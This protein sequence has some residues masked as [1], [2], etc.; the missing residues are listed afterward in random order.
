MSELGKVAK[1]EYVGYNRITMVGKIYEEIVFGKTRGGL[2]Y[3]NFLLAVKD[4][5][6]ETY[7]FFKII[8][9]NALA[10]TI[11]KACSTGALVLVE[12]EIKFKKVKEQRIFE[13]TATRYIMLNNDDGKLEL[14]ENPAD[15]FYNEALTEVT[16]IV[17][18]D[19]DIPF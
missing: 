18:N 10:E 11:V 19:E 8:A 7:N 16:R 14:G 3:C 2:I 15:M 12:G 4:Y 9:W 5:G 17:P 13:V 1:K 6:R